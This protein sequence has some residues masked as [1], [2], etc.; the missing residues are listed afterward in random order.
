MGEI[1]APGE[2][3]IAE[4]DSDDVGRFPDEPGQ[5][6]QAPADVPVPATPD[7]TAVPA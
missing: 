1:G 6:E 5:G 7:P 3:I 4:P 2:I